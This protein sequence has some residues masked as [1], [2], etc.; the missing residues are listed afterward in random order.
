[1]YGAVTTSKRS[2][3]APA[4]YLLEGIP[5]G[6]LEQRQDYYNASF[7]SVH[8][9]TDC[10]VSPGGPRDAVDCSYIPPTTATRAMDDTSYEAAA[11]NA[12]VIRMTNMSNSTNLSYYPHSQCTSSQESRGYQRHSQPLTNVPVQY[13]SPSRICEYPEESMSCA[14][15]HSRLGAPV[16]RSYPGPDAPH[17]CPLCH[18]DER[19]KI[20]ELTQQLKEERYAAEKRIENLLAAVECA[21]AKDAEQE[22][23]LQAVRS[24][25]SRGED[26][27]QRIA[28]ENEFLRRC[29]AQDRSYFHHYTLIFLQSLEESQRRELLAKEAEWRT[30]IA[31]QHARVATVVKEQTFHS[32]T[33]PSKMT[34]SPGL[35]RSLSSTSRSLHFDPFEEETMCSTPPRYNRSGD[36]INLKSG[37][38]SEL[39]TSKRTLEAQ[40]KNLE[41]RLTECLFPS[42][43]NQVNELNQ[44]IT[45][46][47][48]LAREMQS[49]IEDLI[50]MEVVLRER[51]SRVEQERD[52]AMARGEA[53][54]DLCRKE[55]KL[56]QP[57]HPPAAAAPHNLQM[58]CGFAHS[59]KLTY[60]KDSENM[61]KPSA[62]ASG[63]IEELVEQCTSGIVSQLSEVV[64]KLKEAYGEPSLFT[65]TSMLTA[66]KK[67][68]ETH[69]EM[70]S[71]ALQQ[72]LD[73]KKEESASMPS[74]AESSLTKQDTHLESLHS[75]EYDSFCSGAGILR[76]DSNSPQ[77]EIRGVPT[78]RSAFGRI[79]PSSVPR[80]PEPSPTI[81]QV[82]FELPSFDTTLL[83]PR[84]LSSGMAE[85]CGS[86]CASISS[87]RFVVP[88]ETTFNPQAI[89]FGSLPSHEWD[90]IDS[91]DESIPDLPTITRALGVARQAANP[92]DESDDDA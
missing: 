92:F 66:M 44:K 62:L 54:I 6:I 74:P 8:S 68:M 25:S 22:R 86:E 63:S 73:R 16:V 37:L 85:E 89:S 41:G 28:Y 80:S 52:E 45:T 7:E 83:N 55:R 33:T 90:L 4:E 38:L 11:V 76:I 32:L 34:T 18:S 56:A 9:A 19:Q 53:L 15:G 60:Q 30:A 26:R 79:P 27:W 61:Q 39:V 88:E 59:D 10:A 24:E 69:H 17:P 3:A 71:S 14:E 47:Q 5:F 58:S 81:K 77:P 21:K 35:T 23:Q 50:R 84:R 48:R 87:A 75:P 42:L 64:E 40:V 91:S 72:L 70:S 12:T 65:I 43:Q 29:Y 1:M 82:R 31:L 57:L 51:L 78:L 49:E 20:Y 13:R 46:E 67:Q 36:T 2:A